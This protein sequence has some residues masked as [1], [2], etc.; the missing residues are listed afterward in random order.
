MNH[1]TLTLLPL[2]NNYNDYGGRQQYVKWVTERGQSLK[3]EDEFYTNHVVKEYYKNHVKEWIREMAAHVKTIDK[4]HLLEIGFEEIDFA[5]IHIYPEQ[6]LSPNSSDEA[7]QAFVDGWVQAH[8][9]DFNS[10]LKKTLIIGEFGKSDKFPGYSIEK[11]N[12]YFGHVH[13]NTNA[14]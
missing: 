8:I 5:T 11:R 7:Q 13:L 6:W 10:L 2:V 3:N 1:T 4:F 14:S 9:Q 12:N